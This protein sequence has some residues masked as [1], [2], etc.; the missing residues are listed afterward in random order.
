MAG[1]KRKANISNV[2]M[3]NMNI[4]IKKIV[5]NWQLYLLLLPALAYFIIFCYLP[6]YGLQIAFKDFNIRLGIMDSPWVGFKYFEQFFHSIFFKRVFF[7]TLGLG[8]YMMSTVWTPIV[9]A[10]M[11]NEIKS[12]RFMKIVQNISY[13]PFFIST[14][15][16]VGILYLFLSPTEGIV[17]KL[18]GFIGIHPIDF[19]TDPAW[20]KTVY[21]ISNIWT[22]VGWA[23]IIYVAALQGVDPQLVESSIIDGT[24]K[25]QRIW[26]ISIPTILPT[27][28]IILLLNVGVITM[29][30]G[31]G[32][33]EFEKA[34]GMQNALNIDSSDIL[35]TYIYRNGLL[36]S[37]YSF[38]AAVGLFNSVLTMVILI[39]SNVFAKRVSDTYLW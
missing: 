25:L 19:M 6:I 8:A 37:Q 30:T 13:A 36:N 11:I 33:G 27:I 16:L 31:G 2:I 9:L 5:V 35:A 18:I 21:V 12:R 4:K 28:V 10:L 23:S 38:S 17:N 14:I 34:F 20:F 3:R 15:V 24:T 39:F 32:M 1:N 29:N 7:N 26:Y 22:N